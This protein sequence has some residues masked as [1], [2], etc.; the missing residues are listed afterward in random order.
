M[1]VRAMRSAFLTC[2]IIGRLPWYT[3]ARRTLMARRAI[4]YAC[5]IVWGRA[6]GRVWLAACPWLVAGPAMDALLDA[7]SA[8]GAD[9]PVRIERA[10]AAGAYVANLGIAHRADDEVLLDGRAALRAGAVLG[11]LALAQGHVQLLLLAVRR[12]GVRTQDQVG[13]EAH[14]RDEGD[15]AP[16][17]VGAGAAAASVDE[18]I[19]DR[20]HIQ[21][22]DKANEGIDDAHKLRR[23]ELGDVL[24]HYGYLSGYLQSGQVYHGVCLYGTTARGGAGADTN[25][26]ICN[27]WNPVLLFTVTE[28]DERKGRQTNVSICNI[29]NPNPRLT[30]TDRD[31]RFP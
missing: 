16:C 8:V 2:I 10:M 6:A 13:N 23:H 17:H 20:Q 29:W 30:V 7:S 25:I 21:G 22:D 27:I 1:Q 26:S 18:H 24:G 14:K 3:S 11:K 9:L 28:R 15:D 5:F 31:E 19:D 4:F 12:V